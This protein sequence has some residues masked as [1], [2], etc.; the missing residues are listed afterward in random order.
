MPVSTSLSSLLFSN[1]H[2]GPARWPQLGRLLPAGAAVPGA[3]RAASEAQGGFPPRPGPGP[4]PGCSHPA[5]SL[6]LENSH[7]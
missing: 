7:P 1:R 6:S 5:F 4:G 2:W 3:P